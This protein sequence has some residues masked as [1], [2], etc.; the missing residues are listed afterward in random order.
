M[1]G[2]LQTTGNETAQARCDTSLNDGAKEV[3]QLRKD[4]SLCD[5]VSLAQARE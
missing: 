4:W 5:E 3:L 2:M 1:Y